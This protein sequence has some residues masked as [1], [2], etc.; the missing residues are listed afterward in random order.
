MKYTFYSDVSQILLGSRR[1]RFNVPART[2][3]RFYSE[4]CVQGSKTCVIVWKTDLNKMVAEQQVHAF[5]SADLATIREGLKRCPSQP[6]DARYPTFLNTSATRCQSCRTAVWQKKQSRNVFGYDDIWRDSESTNLTAGLI[7]ANSATLAN[8]SV[9]VSGDRSIYI[10]RY[11]S[12]QPQ[13]IRHQTSL[14]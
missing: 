1:R 4:Y 13:I 2:R 12:D 5:R 10:S 8:D 3:R 7:P 11:D 9:Y 14:I 6:R